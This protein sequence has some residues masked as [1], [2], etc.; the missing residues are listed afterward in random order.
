MLAQLKISLSRVNSS[1]WLSQPVVD[2]VVLFN[3]GIMLMQDHSR[4]PVRLSGQQ[5]LRLMMFLQLELLGMRD[6]P[7]GP[8]ADG[9]VVLIGLGVVHVVLVI[10]QV[11]QNANVR[12]VEEG[13]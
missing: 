2:L 13:H 7:V 6:R 8:G 9:H 10:A 5:Q 4:R 3:Q 1:G 12:N 11:G